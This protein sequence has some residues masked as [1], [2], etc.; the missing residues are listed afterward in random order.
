MGMTLLEASMERWKR[1]AEEERVKTREE[2]IEE[3]I[4]QGILQGQRD[5]L[6]RLLEL[7]FGASEDRARRLTNLDR[8]GL[9]AVSR[10]LLTAETEDAIFEES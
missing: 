10:R 2:G 8:E 6:A 5:L 9:E 1:E 7:R 4:E 3:G